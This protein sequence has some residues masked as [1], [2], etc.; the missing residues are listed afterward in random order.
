MKN[1]KSILL[2]IISIYSL[3]SCSH[4]NVLLNPGERMKGNEP[5]YIINKNNDRKPNDCHIIK[6]GD[7]VSL[8]FLNNYDIT[9]TYYGASTDNLT[10]RSGY[11]IDKDG[12]ANFQ[13]VGKI[14][15]SGLTREEASRKLEKLYS[16]VINNPIIEVSIVN[17]KVSLLGEVNNQGTYLIDRDNLTLF[18]LISEAHGLT[19]KAKKK[20]VR[21]IRGD[22]KNPEII[23]VDMRKSKS[24]GYDEL[25]LQDKDI[26][27][28]D[29][30]RIYPAADVFTAFSSFVQPFLALTNIYFISTVV[31]K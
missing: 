7:K 16:N 27:I 10:N 25:S 6:S 20:C 23:L 8:K 30:I 31:S 22:F 17:I 21:I 24:L 2:I 12:F 4:K 18:D 15:L 11:L 19:P 13:L 9:N 26:I 5:V 3:S 29:P 28:V 1:I 14:Q